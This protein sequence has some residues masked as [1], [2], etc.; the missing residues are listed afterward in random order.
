MEFETLEVSHEDGGVMVVT[1]NR[2]DRLNAMNTVMMTELRDLFTDLYVRAD[3]ANCIVITGA[4]DRG[5]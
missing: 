5:F 4:G 1:L 3:Q 2:P